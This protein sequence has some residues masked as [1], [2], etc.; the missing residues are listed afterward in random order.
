[1]GHVI[2]S[3]SSVIRHA[4]ARAC[5]S[6]AFAGAMIGGG[7]HANN[8]G[9]NRT[10]RDSSIQGGHDIRQGVFIDASINP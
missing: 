5:T 6:G 4:P 10:V 2:P 8:A 7:P 1:M 9:A 3:T